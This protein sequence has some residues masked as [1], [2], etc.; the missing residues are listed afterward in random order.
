MTTT[1]ALPLALALATPALAETVSDMLLVGFKPEAKGR[2]GAYWQP[3][4]NCQQLLTAFKAAI[5]DGV[6]MKLGMEAARKYGPDMKGPTLSVAGQVVFLAC[7]HP[8]GSVDKAEIP[9]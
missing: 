5:K 1:V 7:V 4:L 3:P 6:P 8:D 9:K 2:D